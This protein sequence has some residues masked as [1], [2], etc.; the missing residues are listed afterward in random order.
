MGK[1]GKNLKY[2]VK[3][4]I[5]CLVLAHHTIGIWENISPTN[6]KEVTIMTIETKVEQILNEYRFGTKKN[7]LVG[8]FKDSHTYQYCSGTCEPWTARNK[9][10]FKAL[11]EESKVHMFGNYACKQVRAFFFNP[12]FLCDYSFKS[13][14][15][16]KMRK[17]GFSGAEMQVYNYQI[18]G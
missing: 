18:V 1:K 11:L 7:Y 15:I 2:Y 14:L 6:V 16:S 17:V 4:D 13:E 12:M 8:I 3:C 5:I 10:E 9:A